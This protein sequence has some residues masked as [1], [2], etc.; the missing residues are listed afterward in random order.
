METDIPVVGMVKKRVELGSNK[1]VECECLL[2][3]LCGHKCQMVCPGPGLTLKKQKARPKGIIQKVSRRC[4]LR[5][6]KSNQLQDDSV[7]SFAWH[8]I[9]SDLKIPRCD[10]NAYDECV[11]ERET[12]V[13]LVMMN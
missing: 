3:P 11:S 7:D 13:C 8:G 5:T 12:L 9:L 4:V 6:V 10:T 1:G 2:R